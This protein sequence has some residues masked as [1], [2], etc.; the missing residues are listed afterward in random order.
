MDCLC[1]WIHVINIFN[2]YIYYNS[3]CSFIQ[4]GRKAGWSGYKLAVGRLRMI[5]HPYKLA[6]GFNSLNRSICPRD[7]A[8]AAELS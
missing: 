5:S 2:I 7:N 1:N 8:S 3:H 6:V 4:I